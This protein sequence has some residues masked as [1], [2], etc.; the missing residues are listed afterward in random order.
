MIYVKWEQYDVMSPKV[1]RFCY[2][3]VIITKQ[4]ISYKCF[5]SKVVE[6]EIEEDTEVQRS[7]NES[8]AVENES[9]SNTADFPTKI[10]VPASSSNTHLSL[11]RSNKGQ[12]KPVDLTNSTGVHHN[13][14]GNSS[15]ANLIQSPTAAHKAS[16]A[17]KMVGTSHSEKNANCD[18]T[19]STKPKSAIANPSCRFRRPSSSKETAK[20]KAH[21]SH[22][23]SSSWS[24]SMAIH[25][26]KETQSKLAATTTKRPA[27]SSDSSRHS[28]MSKSSESEVKS[29]TWRLPSTAMASVEYGDTEASLEPL[30]NSVQT[31][32]DVNPEC[33]SEA[34][35]STSQVSIRSEQNSANQPS[36]D[37]VSKPTK[38]APDVGE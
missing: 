7:V 22:H 6:M 37:S 30:K 25:K 33:T 36:C 19:T 15:N 32:T 8:V 2:K 14:R 4:S 12:L 11:F 3:N 13:S 23:C 5:S 18:V 31:N 28:K 29:H 1:K 9:T 17:C 10:K 20:S 16:A 35:H 26:S 38:R 27:T 21:N 24:T 34:P